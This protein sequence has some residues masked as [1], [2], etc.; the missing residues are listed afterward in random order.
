[1]PAM[2]LAKL[3]THKV[4]SEPIALLV[5]D[6]GDRCVAVAVRPA[7]AEVIARGSRT[8]VGADAERLTQDLVPALAATLGRHLV[9]VEI[10]DIVG[11]LFRADLVLDDGTRLDARPSD[12]L[13][14]A[15]RD[16]LP[17][18]VA[19]TVVDEVGQSF[20]ELWGDRPPPPHEQVRAL[21]RQLDGATADDFGVVGDD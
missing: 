3:I 13:A 18:L 5:D 11:S 14:L 16:D 8:A 12:A 9:H 20:A 7:Q 4:T 2:H 6:D 15:V 19:G 10:V 1:M 21:R 17:I